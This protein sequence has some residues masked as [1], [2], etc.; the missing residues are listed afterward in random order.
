[1]VNMQNDVFWKAAVLTAVIFAAGIGMGMW[2]DQGRLQEVKAMITESD[3]LGSDVRLQSMIYSTEVLPSGE[4]CGAAITANLNYNDRIYADGKRLE[5]YEKIAKFAPSLLL[6]RKRYAL[7]QMMFWINSLQLK[8]KCGSD[9]DVLLHL[10]LYNVEGNAAL[11]N[12]QKLQSVVLLD[13]KDRCGPGLML[14]NAPAD[15]DIT[16]V[17]MVVNAYNITKFPAVIINKDTVLQGLQN[18]ADL[19]KYFNCSS[20]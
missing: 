16:S 19:E 17:S 13:L 3:I 10:W 4:F 12:E 9:Y 11:D 18:E 6:E 1:M 15:L 2:F 20:A 7:Q 14:S 5:D 8:D